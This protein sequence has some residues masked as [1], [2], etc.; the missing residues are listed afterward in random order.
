MDHKSAMRQQNLDFVQEIKQF[1]ELGYNN[2]S[3]K[4]TQEMITKHYW[5]FR[6]KFVSLFDMEDGKVFFS[7]E[8][9][10]VHTKPVLMALMQ[11]ASND[12]C[13]AYGFP[14]KFKIQ[15]GSDY[16]VDTKK[17]T[18]GKYTAAQI[19]ELTGEK[20]PPIIQDDVDPYEFEN[21]TERL[22]RLYDIRCLKCNSFPDT[23]HAALDGGSFTCSNKK[24]KVGRMHY[25]KNDKKVKTGI[26]MGCCMGNI[27]QKNDEGKKDDEKQ[28]E[29]KEKQIKKKQKK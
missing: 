29:P 27:K 21:H 1:L 8:A 22:V 26:P 23:K 17:Q 12:M 20:R 7:P 16:F 13:E 15:L 28:P 6:M 4:E 19:E 2:I 25:C 10:L 3:E 24:C 18:R 9:R 5:Q 11:E 14:A